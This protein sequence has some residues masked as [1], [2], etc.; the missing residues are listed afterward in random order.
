MNDIEHRCS[1]IAPLATMYLENALA[2]GQ[3][4]SYETHLVFCD[5]CVA[6]LD[7]VRAISDRLRLLPSDPVDDGLRRVIVQDATT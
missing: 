2:P 7:D 1:V 5:S 4:T 6:F 3:I